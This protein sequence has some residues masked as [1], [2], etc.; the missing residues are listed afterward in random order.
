MIKKWNCFRKK[1]KKSTAEIV[2]HDV[3]L[4]NGITTTTT[5]TTACTA[6]AAVVSTK[7]S[8]VRLYGSPTSVPAAYIRFALLHKGVSVRFVPS[9]TPNFG[10]DAPVLQIGSETVSGSLETV[11]RYIDARFPHP[12]LGVRSC[13]EEDEEEEETTPLV[14]RA[15][16]LQHKSM[17]WHVERL[18]RW[19]EDLATR[20]G[21]GSVDPTV[22]SPRMEMKKLARSYSELLEVLLEH[23]QMEERVVFPILEKADRGICKAANE[24][25]ARDLPIMNGIK[26]GIKSIGV[27]DSGSPDYQEALSNLSTRLKSLQEN[28]KQHFME[29]DKD[30]LPFMEAVE[31][32]KEQQKRVLEQCLDVMQGTHS[33]L[34]N[35][36]LEGLLPCE[37]MQYLD[38]FIS[39]NDREQTASTLKLIID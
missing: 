6:A 39:C 7:S 11:L 13:D 23:A 28:S 18:V 31:L 19:V 24:E 3:I 29:E 12:P 2:P 8:T 38:L 37:A 15:I 32:N 25:H 5:G 1:S 33:H 14:V 21:K 36:L 34:F 26:E 4:N 16:A 30:L 17:T 20:G 22:G 27:M 9:D 35:F 10:S